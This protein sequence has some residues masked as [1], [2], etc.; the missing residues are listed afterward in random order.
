[1]KIYSE[2]TNK[3]YKTVDECLEAE[4]QFSEEKEKTAREKELLTQQRK[5]DA[6]QIEDAYKAIIEA[7]KH[8]IE[9]RDKFIEK[10]GSFHMTV[11]NR[12]GEIPFDFFGSI[13]NW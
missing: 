2:L 11:R 1:M 5:E 4:K 3:E 7:N 8:Y 9:L 12:G 13:F 6:K 10:Y